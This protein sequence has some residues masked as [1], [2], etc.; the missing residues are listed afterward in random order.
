MEW[1]IVV[2]V[3]LLGFADLNW[4]AEAPTQMCIGSGGVT[5]YINTG[6]DAEA[7]G[8]KIDPPPSEP[9]TVGPLALPSKKI[10]LSPRVRTRRS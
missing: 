7:E 10:Y 3:G 9:P 5:I 1:P 8:L 2:L 4:G 6:P